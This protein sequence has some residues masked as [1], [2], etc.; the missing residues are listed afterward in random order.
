MRNISEYHSDAADS[1]LSDIL[2]PIGA[3]LSPYYLSAKA[4]RGILERAQRRGKKLPEMLH[5][6]LVAAANKP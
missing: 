5:R 6:A 4:C 3:H 2:E 1:L